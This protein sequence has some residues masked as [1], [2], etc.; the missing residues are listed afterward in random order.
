MDCNKK[1]GIITGVGDRRDED[2]IRMGEEAAKI[3]DEIIIREDDDL[4]GRAKGE[5]DRLIRKG[6]QT[7]APGKPVVTITSEK[8]AIEFGLKKM[9]PNY[10]LVMFVDHVWEGIELIRAKLK[11]P[12]VRQMNSSIA[13]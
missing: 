1:I 3:F 4:R 7:T 6:I 8:K 13:V 10:L 5:V 11:E 9:H 2:I 12:A